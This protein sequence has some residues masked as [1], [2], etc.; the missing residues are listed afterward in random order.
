[1]QKPFISPHSGLGTLCEVYIGDDWIYRGFYPGAQTCSGDI[2]KYSKNEICEFFDNEVYWLKKLESEWIPKT[3]EIGPNYIVQEYSGPALI[4]YMPNL[5]D[6]KE[7]VIEMY[8]FFKQMGVYKR[9]GSV[10]NL[11]MRGDQL[12]A[13]D[14]KWARE[15]PNGIDMELKSYDKWLSK[16]DPSLSRELRAYL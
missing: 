6:V 1:M 10:S 9:N 8:K 13:F 2:T 3:L 16:I 11:T 7:Q 5:P 4:D 14:F 15:R 12:V